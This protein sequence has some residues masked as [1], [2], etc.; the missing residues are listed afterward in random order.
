MNENIPKKMPV[1]KR[2]DLNINRGMAL[3]KIKQQIL[4]NAQKNRFF[5]HT[6]FK[7]FG[8]EKVFDMF[9]YAWKIHSDEFAPKIYDFI[10]L[11]YK[12]PDVEGYRG[13]KEQTQPAKRKFI[14]VV[15]GKMVEYEA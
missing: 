15:D 5:L 3:L 13:R 12:W 8:V 11:Y 10:D 2:S 9:E 14:K 6:L 4:P 7:K 1:R